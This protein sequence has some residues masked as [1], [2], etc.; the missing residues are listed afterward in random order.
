MLW[1]SWGNGKSING[2]TSKWLVYNGYSF[3]MRGIDPRKLGNQQVMGICCHG[4]VKRGCCQESGGVFTP[5]PMILPGGNLNLAKTRAPCDSSW[6]AR[7]SH[8]RRFGSDCFDDIFRSDWNK[9]AL[10]HVHSKTEC[11]SPNC[12]PQQHCRPLPL[13]SITEWRLT[14]MF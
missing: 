4:D 7:C 9:G 10:D 11:S 5:L 8:I 6:S 13:F 14:N 2:S 1:M 12:T 3:K